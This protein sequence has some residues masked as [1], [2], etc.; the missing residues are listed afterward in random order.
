LTLRDNQD[1]K[2]LARGARRR[3][4]HRRRDAI[5]SHPDRRAQAIQIVALQALAEEERF[6]EGGHRTAS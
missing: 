6:A 5:A 2:S 3:D 4:A 1:A